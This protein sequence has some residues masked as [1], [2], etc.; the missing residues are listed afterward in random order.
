MNVK[1]KTLL[2]GLLLSLFI[3][4]GCVAKTPSPAPKTG[5]SD[6]VEMANP[7]A[8]YCVEKGG[9]DEIRTAADGSQSGACVFPDGSEC[10]E[11]AFFRGECAPASQNPSGAQNPAAGMDTML[12]QDD[13]AYKGPDEATSKAVEAVRSLLAAKLNVDAA[14]LQLV[15][16]EPIDWTDACLGIPEEGETCAQVVTPGYRITFSSG[17]QVYTYHTDLPA[18]LIRLEKV[19]TQVG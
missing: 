13:P 10:D 18:T 15:S 7:A 3:I 17:D 11:W 4:S 8:G 2:I 1:I 9:K 14:S 19:A 16:A 12:S 5:Q 6:T